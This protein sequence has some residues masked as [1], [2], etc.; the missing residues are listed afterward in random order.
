ML[1]GHKLGDKAER[2]EAARRRAKNELFCRSAHCASSDSAI[3]I[4]HAIPGL[5]PVQ[6]L[7]V[8]L[9]LQDPQRLLE[10]CEGIGRGRGAWGGRDLRQGGSPPELDAPK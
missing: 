9:C 3:G 8:C 1:F 5:I 10:I 4:R 2:A 7:T 6:M